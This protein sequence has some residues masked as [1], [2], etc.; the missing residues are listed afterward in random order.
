MSQVDKFTDTSANAKDDKGN[1][2][3]NCS[4]VFQTGY[5]GVI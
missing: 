5:A 2:R 3:V 1:M 4:N